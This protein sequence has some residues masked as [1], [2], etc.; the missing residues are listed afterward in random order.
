M[1]KF[2]VALLLKLP[3]EQYPSCLYLTLVLPIHKL[4]DI[5]K[6]GNDAYPYHHHKYVAI[7]S[8]LGRIAKD[9][10]TGGSI[11]SINPGPAFA[12][13]FNMIKKLFSKARLS[14]DN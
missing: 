6:L 4:F 13:R 7:I 8:N 12:S 14:L 9:G 11:G 1:S 3:N 5:Q 10:V 2:I